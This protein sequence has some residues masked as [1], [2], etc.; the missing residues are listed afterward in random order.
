M[1]KLLMIIIVAVVLGGLGYG[2]YDS[3][4]PKEKYE[5]KLWNNI[6]N[7]DSIALFYEEESDLRIEMLRALYNLDK[8]DKGDDE[9][10]YILKIAEAASKVVTLD[11][12][13]DTK[14][15][16]GYDIIRLIGEK[17]IVSAKDMAII[18]R[19][20]I[21]SVGYDARIGEIR[22]SKKDEDKYDIYYIVEYYSNKYN[23]WIAV[24]IVDG[25][26]FTFENTPCSGVELV[27]KG[28]SQLKYIGKVSSEE[29][30]SDKK[31]LF[32]SYTI[33]IDNTVDRVK[34]NSVIT[35]ITSKNEITLTYGDKALMPTI[36][37]ENRELFTKAPNS[38]GEVEDDKA[39]I[40]LMKSEEE[41]VEKFVVGGFKNGKIM[42]EYY[43]GRSNGTFEKVNEYFELELIK[44]KN[45]ISIS[46]DGVNEDARIEI[47][48]N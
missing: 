34:S 5:I 39:Y 29:Y 35:Y 23:K 33:M 43:V 45:M 15:L 4:K 7:G 12:V 41:G 2:I 19:D 47:T 17:R 6:Y 28:V 14:A 21:T 32:K 46:C 3:V 27:E 42:D 24:D 40:I 36:Y 38:E 26:Y 13:D 48:Y 18:V 31:D 9:I 25:G 8:I 22:C 16:N 20:F 44:G 11:N 37:T 30:F 10:N 1:K